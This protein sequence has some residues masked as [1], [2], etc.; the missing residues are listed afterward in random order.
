MAVVKTCPLVEIKLYIFYFYHI[1]D[2]FQIDIKEE[3]QTALQ[4]PPQGGCREVATV[5][6][7]AQVLCKVIN[8]PHTNNVS[9]CKYLVLKINIILRDT[10]Y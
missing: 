10:A 6:A 8:E 4:H 7:C 2:L 9:M 5:L 3:V 1:S